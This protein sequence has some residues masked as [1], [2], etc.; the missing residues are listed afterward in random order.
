MVDVNVRHRIGEVCTGQDSKKNELLR[1]VDTA[2]T[3]RGASV[4][5]RTRNKKTVPTKQ[6]EHKIA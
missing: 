6:T 4:A 3:L 5:H 2:L 1:T